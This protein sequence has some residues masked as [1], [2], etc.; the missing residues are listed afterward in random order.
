MT[1]HVSTPDYAIVWF[2]PP[3]LRTEKFA[4]RTGDDI[5]FVTASN[6]G[7]IGGNFT[8]NTDRGQIGP[9]EL[10]T[11]VLLDAH[12]DAVAIQTASGTFLSAVNAGGMGGNAPVATDSVQ[13]GAREVFTLL[14]QGGGKHA[15]QTASGHFLIAVNAGGMS[16]TDPVHTDAKQIGPWERF[17]LV[18][19]RT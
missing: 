13:A 17:T 6:G 9:W 3:L 12:T 16:G 4:L 19:V 1:G 15:L 11:I 8:L 18:P 2:A 7:G 5:H 10:F 14:P